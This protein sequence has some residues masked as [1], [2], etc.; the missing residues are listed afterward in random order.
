VSKRLVLLGSTGSIGE[1]ALRVVEALPGAFRVTGLAARFEYEKLLAQ[2]VRF[3]VR[4]V[5]V[6]DAEAARRCAAAA[7]SGVR[8]HAGEAG[9]ERLA[10]EVEADIV[11]CSVVGMAGLKPVLA[12]LRA[13]RDVALATKEVLVA[14]GAIVTREAA[15][16]GA[17]LLPVDSEHSALSQCLAGS[18]GVGDVRRL[19]LT[20]SG[21]PFAAN[22]RIDFDTVT[23]KEALRHPSWN[24]GRKVT[25]DSATLMNKGLEVMEAHW[26]FGVPIERIEVVIHPESVVHSL[27]EYV[28]GSVLAQLSPPDM[29]YAI[30]YALTWPERRDGA[31]PRLDLAA[32]GR[33]HF[34]S[35]D[36]ARFPCLGLAREAALRGG[37]VPAALNAANEVAVA[38]FLEGRIRFSGIWKLVGHV[39]SRHPSVAD[40]G[41]DD[42]LA[43]DAAARR[44]AHA[45][46]G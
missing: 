42:I 27:V 35:P 24:M 15:R 4:D 2:A 5:A 28:D 34:R 38:K 43:A 9:L 17:R 32:V 22:E 12:A 19:I 39:T 3:G 25:I 6:A 13:R 26:L 33:L 45:W 29:R 1:S 36:E 21:G 16:G 37:T 31:L 20:A 14:A 18:R 11:L 23:V 7:P 44:E 41:L 30:Q 10:G 40:P 46:E 8:V